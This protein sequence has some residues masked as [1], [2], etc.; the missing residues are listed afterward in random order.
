MLLF[1]GFEGLVPT[2]CDNSCVVARKLSL[3]QEKGFALRVWIY[4]TRLLHLT[5]SDM[6][7]LNANEGISVNGGPRL[8]SKIINI[9]VFTTAAYHEVSTHLCMR[10]A[11]IDKETPLRC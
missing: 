9:V 7:M 8:P 10:D 11:A 1:I 5:C 2:K 6:N 4:W 3:H